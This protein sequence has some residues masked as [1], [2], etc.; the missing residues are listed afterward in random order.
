MDAADIASERE[1]IH[2]EESLARARK[3]Q[4]S[5]PGR[6]TCEDCGERIPEDRKK[7]V[8][9]CTR[10]TGCQKEHDDE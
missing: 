6:D 2:R 5:G 8:P 3:A 9:G 7:A 10:C 1:A 4:A